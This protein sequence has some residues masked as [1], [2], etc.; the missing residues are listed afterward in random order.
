MKKI[1]YSSLIGIFAFA[2]VGGTVALAKG[3]GFGV[4]LNGQA[5]LLGMT[6]E[7]LET[8]LETKDMPELLDEAG[9][10]HQ[11]L[12]QFRESNRLEGPAEILGMTTEEL[13]SALE[14][15][16]YNQ[17]LDEAGISHEQFAEMQQ[18]QRREHITEHL[19]QMVDDGE[20]TEEAMQER[21]A[22]LEEMDGFG[23]RHDMMGG[24][25]GGHRG[26][27]DFGFGPNF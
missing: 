8:A 14:G 20:I 17:L 27:M 2:L 18:T 6:T 15:K 11:Q 12:F 19:Q 3:W 10:T 7:E 23:G 24:S 5:E 21:L 22:D 1:I 9:V 4:D 25:G 16:T 26:G 13:H